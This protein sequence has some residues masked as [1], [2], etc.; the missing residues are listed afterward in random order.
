MNPNGIRYEHAVVPLRQN[1]VD[2]TFFTP[3]VNTNYF[4]THTGS[5]GA[6]AASRFSEYPL[7]HYSTNTV[8]LPHSA[9]LLPLV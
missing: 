1:H 7:D 4:D 8:Y 5:R 9:L 3:W 6:Q 2:V